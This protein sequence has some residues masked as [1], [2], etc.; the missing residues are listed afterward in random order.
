MNDAS[1]DANR[2]YMA[3]RIA[4]AIGGVGIDGVLGG[5][6]A[7]MFPPMESRLVQ[8]SSREEVKQTPQPGLRV[9]R[10][11]NSSRLDVGSAA[12][13]PCATLERHVVGIGTRLTD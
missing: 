11:T 2:T 3:K 8:L 12:D 9:R 5:S 10:S 1:P 13:R 7:V 4:Y 6:T